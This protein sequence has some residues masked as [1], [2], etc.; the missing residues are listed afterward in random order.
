MANRVLLLL[1]MASRGDPNTSLENLRKIRYQAT[2]GADFL[3]KESNLKIGCSH[4][5]MLEKKSES[6]TIEYQQR[7]ASQR[8]PSVEKNEPILSY[9]EH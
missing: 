9:N 2:T 5:R 6:R 8:R 4:R 3:T 1:T 7:R